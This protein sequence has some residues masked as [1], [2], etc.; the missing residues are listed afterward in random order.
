MLINICKKEIFFPLKDLES[1]ANGTLDY[2]QLNRD[3]SQTGTTFSPG[4]AMKA[5]DFEDEDVVEGEEEE[6]NHSSHLD[7]QVDV[8]ISSDKVRKRE[9]DKQR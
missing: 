9:Q 2:S 1:K 4:T 5:Q 6:Q 8:E 7:P 3:L